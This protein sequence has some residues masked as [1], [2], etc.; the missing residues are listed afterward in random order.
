MHLAWACRGRAGAP[1]S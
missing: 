1:R